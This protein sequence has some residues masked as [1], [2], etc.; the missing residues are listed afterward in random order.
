MTDDAPT[1]AEPTPAQRAVG[2][3]A[4]ALARLTDEVLFGDVWARKALPPRDRSLI[5]VAALI[6][7]GHGDQL[8]FHFPHALDNGVTPDELVETVTHLAFYS[9]WPTA[10]SAVARLRDALAD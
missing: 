7:L 5:T 8:E 4:P 9:G 10:V 6:A 1:S 3:I 2:D